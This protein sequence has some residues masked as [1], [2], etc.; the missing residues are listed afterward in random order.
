LAP[1]GYAMSGA[2]TVPT[3]P[4]AYYLADGQPAVAWW[5]CGGLLFRAEAE[6]TTWAD[7]PT[8]AW[9]TGPDG[10]PA[11]VPTLG[12]WG[13]AVGQVQTMDW[14]RNRANELVVEQN[15]AQQDAHQ[16]RAERDEA[17]AERA[18]LTEANQAL[19]RRMAAVARKRNALA[20]ERD[21]LRSEVALLR[22]VHARWQALGEALGVPE[23][24]DAEAW[25]K[26]LVALSGAAMALVAA[27]DS[28]SGQA[29]ALLGLREALEA[30]HAT[31]PMPD[32]PGWWWCRWSGATKYTPT[33]VE[34]DGGLLA[35]HLDGLLAA[36]DDGGE[37]EWLAGPDG[38]AVRCT[39]PGVT[40]A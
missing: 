2:K 29:V 8:A 27:T 21:A 3:E 40:R 30:L 13:E 15:A 32:G 14:W 17:I 25:A 10:G 23:G 33:W 24:V 1:W 6:S 36:V 37:V 35:R 26:A 5:S 39:P 28:E 9:A 12:E 19:R 7:A 4:G 31:R 18:E 20:D 22:E 34:N 16:A 11:R 38:K